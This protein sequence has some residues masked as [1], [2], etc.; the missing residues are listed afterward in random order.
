MLIVAQCNLSFQPVRPLGELFLDGQNTLGIYTWWAL[1]HKRLMSYQSSWCSKG[2]LQLPTL[3]PSLG[4]CMHP[5]HAPM[6]MAART[7]SSFRNDHEHI[8]H[9]P[10]GIHNFA[11]ARGTRALHVAPVRRGTFWSAEV[12]SIDSIS[13]TCGH[14]GNLAE[15]CLE[16]LSIIMRLSKDSTVP[17]SPKVALEILFEHDILITKYYISNFCGRANL[18]ITLPCHGKGIAKL[19]QV[20]PRVENHKTCRI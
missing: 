10:I 14:G 18:H 2:S 17:T 12:V 7:P 16:D 1:N 3:L 8:I 4:K 20:I 13:F 15:F 6:A 9:W 11:S 19:R 5:H